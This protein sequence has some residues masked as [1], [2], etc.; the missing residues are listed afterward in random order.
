MNCEYIKRHLDSYIDGELK[1][2]SIAEKVRKHIDV[3]TPCRREFEIG[4]DLKHTV[5]NLEHDDPSPYLETRI[6]AVIRSEQRSMKRRVL[7][8]FVYSTAFVIAF[9]VFVWAG[10]PSI[11]GR[12][13]RAL[14]GYSELPQGGVEVANDELSADDFLTFAVGNHRAVQSEMEGLKYAVDSEDEFKVIAVKDSVESGK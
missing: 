9:A 10:I 7:L 6:L 1:D 8:R 14:N 13:Y 4:R 5:A 3:C 2:V 12:Q 11:S